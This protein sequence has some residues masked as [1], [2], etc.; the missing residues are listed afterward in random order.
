MELLGMIGPWQI[1]IIIIILVGI[2]LPLFALIDILKSEFA[3]ND[4]LIWVL[5]VLILPLLGTLLYFMIG[6]QHKIGKK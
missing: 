3:G 5:V 2:L 6:S 1:V 4:K